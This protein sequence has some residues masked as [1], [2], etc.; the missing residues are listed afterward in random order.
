MRKSHG[1]V[2]HA[3][4]HIVGALARVHGVADFNQ[5]QALAREGAGVDHDLAP[6]LAPFPVARIGGVV[7]KAQKDGQ[8]Q[9]DQG[10]RNRRDRDLGVKQIAVRHGDDDGQHDVDGQN[11]LDALQHRAPD[12]PKQL[13]ARRAIPDDHEKRKF[14]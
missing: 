2:H 7:A 3:H 13:E 14:W 6:E 11:T 9:T 10:E 1:A 8:R 4:P 12:N 5:A